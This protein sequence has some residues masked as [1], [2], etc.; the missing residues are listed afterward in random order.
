LEQITRTT[1][2]RLITLQLGHIFLTDGRTFISKSLEFFPATGRWPRARP[3]PC[4]RREAGWNG[5]LRDRR[6][7]RGPSPRSRAQPDRHR[8]EGALR[9][10]PSRV[11]GA[12]ARTAIVPNCW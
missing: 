9:R 5:C 1:P 3:L 2:L 10:P 4:P 6:R 7:E 11:G 12:G 8:W